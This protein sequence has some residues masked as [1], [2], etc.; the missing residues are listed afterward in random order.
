MSYV[1]ILSVSPLLEDS[2][3]QRT[4]TLSRWRLFR[5]LSK[6]SASDFKWVVFLSEGFK[7]EPAT[8]AFHPAAFTLA[9]GFSQAV[10]LT[11]K[12]YEISM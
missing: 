4:T 8:W 5:N 1:P 10:T 7:F 6:A 3:F 11:I 9:T 2:V 12:Q